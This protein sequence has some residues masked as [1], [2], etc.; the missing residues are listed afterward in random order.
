MNI[1]NQVNQNTKILKDL[2]FDN[3]KSDLK[4]SQK[5]KQELENNLLQII[6]TI[7]THPLSE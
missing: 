2:D 4:L 3:L 6:K 1:N 7:N 5:K